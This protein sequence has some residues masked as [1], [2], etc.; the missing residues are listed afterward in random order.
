M[1]CLR[2]SVFA[3][4]LLVAGASTSAFAGG[5]FGYPVDPLVPVPAPIPIP[6]YANTFYLRGDFSWAF[7]ENPDI[8]EPGLA[9]SNDDI[10]DAWS[11]G[12]GF[13]YN[14]RDKF[15]SDITLDQRF[16]ANISATDPAGAR[17]KADLS[18]TV[19]LANLYY[20]MLGR[21]RFTPYVGGAAACA[22]RIQYSV[23]AR[24]R[25]VLPG[26][27]HAALPEGHQDRSSLTPRS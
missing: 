20:D 19:V 17:H 25:Y 7:H 6:D 22:W 9:Y 10:D 4:C 13:G 3:A 5:G 8:G 1:A 26:R 14:F 18:S 12:V 21:D 16:D 15:R 11:L 2:R 27:C 23:P 24:C